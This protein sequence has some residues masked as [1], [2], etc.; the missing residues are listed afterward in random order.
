MT[1]C[2]P[3]PSFDTDLK[4][5]RDR[6]NPETVAVRADVRKTVGCASDDRAQSVE[7]RG[8]KHVESG[9]P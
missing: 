4:L 5:P 9:R 7:V 2:N 1:G 8:I 3:D 6:L